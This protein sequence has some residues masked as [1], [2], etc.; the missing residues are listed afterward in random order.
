MPYK[1][2]KDDRCPS[3]RPWG[4][5]NA[6]TNRLLGCHSS[7]QKA[8]IQEAIVVKAE[9]GG[10]NMGEH[11]FIN[12]WTTERTLDQQGQAAEM[13]AGMVETRAP[14]EIEFEEE[15]PT[16]D[17]RII[18]E[19]ATNFDREPP[20]P[21]MMTTETSSG[22]D[23]AR[24][25]GVIQSVKRAGK[26]VLGT[27]FLDLGSEAGVEAHR[28][29]DEGIL[30]TWSPDMGNVM[31]EVEVLAEDEEG[32]PSKALMHLRSGTLLGG[33]MVPFPALSSAKVRLLAHAELAAH[34]HSGPL[35]SM[36]AAKT[37]MQDQHNTMP[38]KMSGMTLAEINQ[39]HDKMHNAASAIAASGQAVAPP[40]EWFEDPHLQELTALTVTDEGRVFGH[41]AP[42]GECHIGVTDACLV[43]PHSA[44]DY[45]YF[46]TGV[47]KTQEGVMVATGPITFNTDHAKLVMGHHA[48][49]DHYAHTGMAIAD[50]AVGE[51][52]YG[53][54][55]AGALRPDTSPQQLRV[56][57][58]SALSGD[59]RYISGS[60]ELIA[61]L[62]VNVPGYPVTRANLTAGVQTALVA[63]GG[64]ALLHQTD[65]VLRRIAAL[66]AELARWAI[67]LNP[68]RPAARDAIAASVL[69][70]EH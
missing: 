38:G 69:P 22:H 52:Q 33:T 19:N 12:G 15:D 58:A 64:R 21:F 30:S 53:I 43:A 27:G 66:E 31:A 26:K 63:A 44:S 49:A 41:A 67:V 55:V 45:A 2:V 9:Q 32:F 40:L 17:G 48:A 34:T 47:I 1:V 37:H 54:W 46:Q 56:L 11:E 6:Q 68:L 18:D 62:A 8:H 35:G 60:L 20:L 16:V 61:L 3:D 70:T 10:A 4:L 51:D 14:F 25:A 36:D 7:A 5:V 65:P 42:W 50:V 23:G 24:L 13:A 29:L 57:R 39:M 59:W 28:L